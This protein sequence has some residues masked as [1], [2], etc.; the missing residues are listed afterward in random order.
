MSLNK[1]PSDSQLAKFLKDWQ[2]LKMQ[3]LKAIQQDP[4]IFG[5][6]QFFHKYKKLR[7]LDDGNTQEVK[8]DWSDERCIEFQ[9]LFD[10]MQ[11]ALV[12]L[13]NKKR[14]GSAIN[15]WKES[16]L[17][18]D[19]VRNCRVLCWLFDCQGSGV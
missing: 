17:K 7:P 12:S 18:R 14:Q 10:K 11:P 2:E 5:L 4:L 6:Q 3:Q 19:E 15:V 16:G 1:L 8:I 13:L 9:R